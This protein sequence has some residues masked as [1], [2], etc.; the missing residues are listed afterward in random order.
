[1]DKFKN[2]FCSLQGT[3]W[4]LLPTSS[5]SF[6]QLPSLTAVLI[7]RTR[8]TLSSPSGLHTYYSAWN[9]S[10]YLLLYIPEPQLKSHFLWEDLP[11]IQFPQPT[12]TYFQLF[13]IISYLI[14]CFLRMTVSSRG[15]EINLAHK[16]ILSI[17]HNTQ[18]SRYQTNI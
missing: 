15:T 6:V 18:P 2:P 8:H 5:V 13:T 7:S 10:P 17:Q 12:S 11:Y 9:T 16:D 4:L 1:M 14:I 3:T